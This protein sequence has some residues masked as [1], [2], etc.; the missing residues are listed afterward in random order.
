MIEDNNGILDRSFN[1][2]LLVLNAKEFLGIIVQ[3]YGE[4]NDDGYNRTLVEIKAE[5]KELHNDLTKDNI[6]EEFKGAFEEKALG[7]LVDIC[8]KIVTKAVKK[9]I[10]IE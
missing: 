7:K 4:G 8:I 9:R 10:G 2:K 6:L 1:P 3:I 5:M